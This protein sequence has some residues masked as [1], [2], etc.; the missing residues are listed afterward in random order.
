MI[1]QILKQMYIVYCLFYT[2]SLLGAPQITN[3]KPNFGPSTG[4]TEVTINGNGFTGAD[5]VIFGTKA[6]KFTVVNGNQITASTPFNIPGTCNVRVIVNG[7][8]SPVNNNSEYTYQAA[9]WFMYVTNQ[10]ASSVTPID[11]STNSPKAPISVESGPTNIAITPNGLLGF[12][13]NFGE[14]SGDTVSVFNIAIKNPISLN[15]PVPTPF[16]VAITPDGSKALV[17]SFSTNTIVTINIKTLSTTSSTFSTG[18]NPTGI[19]ITPD[20]TKV[21]V[22]NSFD[23]TVSIINLLTGSTL[24]TIAA[25]NNPFAIAI[26]PDGTRAFVSNVGAPPNLNS[27]TITTIDLTTL[28]L[29]TPLTVGNRPAGIAISPDGKLGLVANLADNSVTVFDPIALTTGQEIQVGNGPTGIAIAPDGSTAFVTNFNNNNVLP[30]DLTI[31]PYQTQDPIS[32]GEGPQG[33]AITPDQPHNANFTV[34]EAPVGEPTVFDA[35]SSIPVI[36]TIV[37]YKWDFGDGS[38]TVITEIPTVSHIYTSLGNYRVTLTIT[39]SAGTSITKVFT[40]QTMSRNGGRNSLASR[41]VQIG[42]KPA[43][44]SH[45]RGQLIKN[46]FATQTDYIHRLTWEPSPDASTVRYKLFRNDQ[47]IGKISGRGPFTF[48]DHNRTKD[49]KDH[50]V[51]MAVNRQ[52]RESKPVKLT[53]PR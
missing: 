10:Q 42:V 13:A 39:N 6:A 47:L 40:G 31:F 23:N 15:I 14:G 17:T 12:V 27:T 28:S 49:K 38:P 48:D 18:N 25:V 32:T 36:G 45:F 7:V 16:S 5:K 8:N 51:L 41:T 44:P 1:Q 52:G 33:I 43:P 34:N 4:G 50:Y 21:L 29:S 2:M 26:T 24:A 37:S 3:I 22:A 46:E 35:S 11:L 19:A 30:I 9:D 20:G 53:L